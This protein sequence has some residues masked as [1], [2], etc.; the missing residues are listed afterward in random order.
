[1]V[2]SRGGWGGVVTL[3]PRGHFAMFRDTFSCR[4]LGYRLLMVLSGVRSELLL[5]VQRCTE[6]H[7]P[8]QQGIAGPRK[9]VV[10]TLRK[11]DLDIGGPI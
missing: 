5:N 6:Q 11:P 3:P 8:S 9:P 7:L 1:M 2:L 4:S 10:P